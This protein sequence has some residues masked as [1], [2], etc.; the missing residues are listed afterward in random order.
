MSI[1][2][3]AALRMQLE[4]ALRAHG[5]DI[6]ADT[7]R[8]SPSHVAIQRAMIREFAQ[9]LAAVAQRTGLR[10]D[11][12]IENSRVI[13]I[14]QAMCDGLGL[15]ERDGRMDGMEGRRADSGWQGDG[16]S[17]DAL[18]VRPTEV[19]REL[20]QS[21]PTRTV[22]A[23]AEKARVRG[24]KYQ[25]SAGIL[26]P[27]QTEFHTATHAK[28]SE[29]RLIHTLHTTTRTDWQTL[30][31][32]S[33]SGINDLAEDAESARRAL[34]DLYEAVLVEGLSGTDM[35]GLRGLEVAKIISIV[36][37][38]TATLGEKYAELARMILEVQA[39][40]ADRG[41]IPNTLFMATDW[42][43]TIIPSNNLDVGGSATGAELVGGGVDMIAQLNAN[44]MAFQGVFS[45][46]GITR[47]IPTP[48]LNN[49]GRDTST[50]N[51][52]GALLC[53]LP[54]S[55]GLRKIVAV[56]TSP[57]RTAQDLAGDQ[58]LWIMRIGDV[59]TPIATSI[60]KMHA[61]VR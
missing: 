16:I 34:A 17:T 28:E 52:A 24:I 26:L 29:T 48:S 42:L 13:E 6:R 39:K 8:R 61:R 10:A 47:I 57:V 11:T 5:G 60:G 50:T 31:W 15:R 22:D 40:N 23:N 35:G 12:P 14:M 55:G 36:N 9:N 27:G 41:S 4:G 7:A 25:G 54:E 3:D 38:A 33:V 49:F 18:I 46:L 53:S 58:T 19:N 32:G 20:T 45:T 51:E 56:A 1:I 37:F 59:E 2:S 30:L 44:N 21:I 43:R